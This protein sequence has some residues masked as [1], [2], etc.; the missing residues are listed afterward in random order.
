[1]SLAIATPRSLR[2]LCYSSPIQLLRKRLIW[3]K[4]KSAF[5]TVLTEG[6]GSRKS[7]IVVV[8]RDAVP[9]NEG[10]RHEH[11]NTNYKNELLHLLH[12]LSPPQ[13]LIGTPSFESC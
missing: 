13:G 10:T 8:A 12:G 11:K 3:S 1:M 2:L 7:P 9:A 4:M 5:F 6:I